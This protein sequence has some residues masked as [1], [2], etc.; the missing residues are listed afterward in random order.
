MPP[1]RHPDFDSNIS[2]LAV[3][4]K[5]DVL[6]YYPYESFY[7]VTDVLREAAID[8]KVKSIKISLYRLAT[9]S[10]V[11][12]A[13]INAVKNGKEVTAVLE[14]EA[15]F[16]EEANIEWSN[17]MQNAGVNIQFG[18]PG[19]KVHSKI[20]LITR[21]EGKVL[22]Q[23]A[24]VGA[25]NFHEGTAHLYTDHALLTSDKRITSEV[26][27]VFDF[28]KHQ[29]KTSRYKHLLVSPTSTRRS[30]LAAIQN[31]IKNAKNGKEAFI[32]IK[33][34]NLLDQAL[35][36]KLYDASNAGVKVRCI[37]RGICGLV[38]GVKGVSENI[39]VRSIVDRF[40]E[41]SRII[42]FCNGG[43]EKYYISSADW[44]VRNLDKRLEVTVPIYDKKLQRQL[45][46]VLELQLSDNVKA[47]NITARGE[48]TYY[49]PVGRKRKVRSQIEIYKYYQRLIRE[50]EEAAEAKKAE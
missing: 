21:K 33:M 14:L 15:R 13:L 22:K 6:L 28:L 38:P 50:Y 36:N 8:P 45:R 46:D 35:I 3:F 43:D 31:E 17:I 26:E 39:E 18:V 44:M 25:G 10:R 2:K 23:Y 41:H 4:A 32:I 7:Y 40:L 11:V 20:F 24:Y 27:K 48:N 30:F 49:R 42:V 1:L 16:D 9:E 29:Y 12:N 34:N 37:V 47:R 19:L 5:K